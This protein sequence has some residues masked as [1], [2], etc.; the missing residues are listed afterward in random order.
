MEYSMFQ[1]IPLDERCPFEIVVCGNYRK[2]VCPE[3]GQEFLT[4]RQI[5]ENAESLKKEHAVYI[6][7]NDLT[8]G[9]VFS[10][11]N[12]GDDGCVYVVGTTVGYA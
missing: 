2:F 5:L 1:K 7:A 12:Y 10:Y 6:I 8:K 4:F 9:F 11:G 3:L